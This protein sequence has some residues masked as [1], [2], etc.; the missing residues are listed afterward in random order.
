MAFVD[1]SLVVCPT[2]GLSH[3]TVASLHWALWVE[4]AA[5]RACD[6]N[7]GPVLLRTAPGTPDGAEV[8]L[9]ARCARAGTT[10]R[11]SGIWFLWQKWGATGGGICGVA[12]LCK[13][14]AGGA[15]QTGPRAHWSVCWGGGGPRDTELSLLAPREGQ[16]YSEGALER[17]GCKLCFLLALRTLAQTDIACPLKQSAITLRSPK[18]GKLPCAVCAGHTD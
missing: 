6:A 17:I 1:N 10:S 13:E 14:K 4:R 2:L 7:C 18:E 8:R 12:C 16:L 15:T 9:T 3:L 11:C 5:A